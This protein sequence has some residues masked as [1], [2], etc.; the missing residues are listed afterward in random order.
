MRCFLPTSEMPSEE[1]PSLPA[2]SQS[3]VPPPSDRSS[4]G[5]SWPTT[6]YPPNDEACSF[7]GNTWHQLGEIPDLHPREI[8]IETEIQPSPERGGFRDW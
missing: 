3:R 4:I 6:D 5:A 8:V 7:V 1:L 2:S